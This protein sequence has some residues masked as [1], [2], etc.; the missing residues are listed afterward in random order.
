M[1]EKNIIR[2]NIS[3]LF[4][5]VGAGAKLMSDRVS[6]PQALFVLTSLLNSA[7]YHDIFKKAPYLGCK[8]SGKG[9]YIPI[10]E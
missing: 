8:Q 2:L 7:W 10:L 6:V 1:T 5:L 3:D 4:R 9:W